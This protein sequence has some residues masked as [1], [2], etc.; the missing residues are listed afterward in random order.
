MLK[1]ASEDNHDWD[2]YLPYALFEYRSTPHSVTGFT[3][4]QLNYGY[5][6]RGPLEALC[7]NWIEGTIPDCNLIEWVERMKANILDFS[8]MACNHT[9]LAKG[10]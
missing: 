10:K 2:I 3:P 5:D 4:F 7:E 1:K 8:T 6:V 9:A